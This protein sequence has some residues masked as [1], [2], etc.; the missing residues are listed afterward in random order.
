MSGLPTGTVV[1]HTYSMC[2]GNSVY[3]ISGNIDSDFNLTVW[4]IS[5]R[6]PN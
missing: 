3:H 2:N 4:Q 1:Y 6:L 5:Y